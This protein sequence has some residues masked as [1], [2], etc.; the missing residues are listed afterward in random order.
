VN[1]GLSSEQDDF[2]ESIRGFFEAR[3]GL[4]RTREAVE[5]DSAMFDRDAWLEMAGQVGLQATVIP[6]AWEGFGFGPV[7]LAIVFE[8]AGRQLLDAPLLTSTVAAAMLAAG[9]S[10]S[11]RAEW[12][13][14]LASGDAVATAAE[15]GTV[16]DSVVID[17]ENR[18]TGTVE[19]VEAAEFAD[20]LLIT[21]E[22]PEGP[23]LVALR[24]DGP[25]LEV[26]TLDT[27]DP[28]RNVGSVRMEGAS[29]EIAASLDQA[30]IANAEGTRLGQLMLA[31]EE[32]GASAA[33]LERTVEYAS[34]RQQ[35]GR[36]IGQFQAVKHRL[37]TVFGEL[38][39]TRALL[40]DAARLLESDDERQDLMVA[41]ARCASGDL[42][43]HAAESGIH[44][45][46]GVG[47]TWEH[48]AH[49]FY[50]RVQMNRTAC[51][52]Y[53]A[54]RRRVAAFAGWV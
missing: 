11:V 30:R 39:S 34:D 45:H 38:V 19:R 33:I 22:G 27:I 32:T 28:S 4:A 37:A 44:V 5:S 20:L 8:E 12:L 46:G 25:G 9:E 40:Y 52:G 16:C 23:V 17:S 14:R 50:R 7:E 3:Y 18:L 13:P 6:E 36:P 31:A 21:V 54:S 15:V 41:T 47:F 10:D 42:S 1:L 48:D 35:F 29:A 43:L 49:L 53:A 2:R 26:N 24:T 51:G